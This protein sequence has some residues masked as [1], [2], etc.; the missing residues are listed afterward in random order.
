MPPKSNPQGSRL[1]QRLL[2][3]AL[4]AAAVLAAAVGSL[5]WL[6]YTRSLQT[7]TKVQVPVLTIV[8][9][10]PTS[11]I[12][13]L[14]DI[15]VKNDTPPK[16]YEFGVQT[17]MDTQY[18]L[19]LAHTT[20]IGL[21][22]S[23]YKADSNFTQGTKL[24]GKY[25]N[26]ESETTP[27]LADATGTYHDKTYGEY[28]KVQENAEPLYWQSYQMDIKRTTPQYFILEVSW[29]NSIKNNKETDMVYLTAGI[30]GGILVSSQNGGT[31]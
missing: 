14:G 29:D 15:D 31:Q 17:S 27:P 7:Y 1:V 21:R 26:P 6:R 10:D 11:M 3:L 18:W 22:F 24:D 19:Q 12:I 2:L 9:K 25:L 20:N 4:V 28:K 8:G 16:R 30:S 13:D 23:I 5:A